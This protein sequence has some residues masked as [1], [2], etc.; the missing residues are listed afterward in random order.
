MD[1]RTRDLLFGTGNASLGEAMRIPEQRGKFADLVAGMRGRE[2]VERAIGRPLGTAAANAR[3]LLGVVEPTHGLRSAAGTAAGAAAVGAAQVEYANPVYNGLYAQ[4]LINEYGFVP[5]VADADAPVANV[6]ADA[7]VAPVAE[8]TAPAATAAAGE[9][10][11]STIAATA[12]DVATKVADLEQRMLGALQRLGELPSGR[13][14]GALTHAVDATAGHGGDAYDVL[15]RSLMDRPLDVAAPA[16]E[17]AIDDAAK[18]VAP[19]VDDAAKASAPVAEPV[20]KAV[21]PAAKQVA[22]VVAPV[23]D[24]VAPRIV[25]QAGADDALRGVKGFAAGI[26][27]TLRLLAQAR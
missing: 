11:T 26:D 13:Q 24:A 20:V 3:G 4:S 21:A 2:H 25:F 22:K 27:D 7:P 1:V 19:V 23:A 15:A 6:I 12:D 18:V 10:P 16:L 8:A 5:P 9:A 17:R 14:V